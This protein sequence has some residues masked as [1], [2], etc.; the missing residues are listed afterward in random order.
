MSNVSNTG[1][2]LQDTQVLPRRAESPNEL[3]TIA[4][5]QHS[6]EEM[7]APDANGRGGVLQSIGRRLPR[8]VHPL[9]VTGPAILTTYCSAVV[10]DESPQKV[11]DAHSHCSGLTCQLQ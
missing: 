10:T 8:Q 1:A 3:S 6:A 2:P 7:H 11:F 4:E 5:A 9:S